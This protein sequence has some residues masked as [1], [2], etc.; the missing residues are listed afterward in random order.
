[1]PGHPEKES[2]EKA[3]LQLTDVFGPDAHALTATWEIR[4]FEKG[5]VL[6]RIGDAAEFLG[7]I[8]QGEVALKKGLPSY[9][10]PIIIEMLWEGEFF[11]QGCF[12]PDNRREMLAEVMQPCELAMLSLERYAMLLANDPNAVTLLQQKIIRSVSR[13]LNRMANRLTRLF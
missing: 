1:M 2:Q 12:E 8:L 9:G 10:R 13:R 5:E 6:W 7:L 3:V 4:R 11:G